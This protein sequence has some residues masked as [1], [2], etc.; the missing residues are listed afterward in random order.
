MLAKSLMAQD[1]WQDA[2]EQF[3]AISVGLKNDPELFKAR[4][5]GDVDWA[6]ALLATGKITEARQQ[7]KTGLKLT[8]RQ[9][10]QNHYRTA[11]IRGAIAA[12]HAADGDKETAMAGFA[13]AVPIILNQFR[14]TDV[15]T[16]TRSTQDPYLTFTLESYMN[17][18]ADIHGSPLEAKMKIDAL[19][20][21]FT[22]ADFVRAHAV[23]RA[24]SASSVRY[25]IKDPEL[26]GLVRSEQDSA[27][28]LD[29]LY[30]TLAVAVTQPTTANNP[31]AIQSLRG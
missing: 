21:S 9:L 17:L 4:F 10:G 6:I 23:Q 29:A 3:E 20:T 31:E 25:G 22:L 24:V 15:A 19:E 1:R 16:H 12:A 2:I 14:K 27:K 28:R 7:L 5:A 18:L 11:I 30:G 13:E 8:S 26:A